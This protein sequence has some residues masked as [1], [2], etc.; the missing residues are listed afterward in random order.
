LT[1][2]IRSWRSSQIR[3]STSR[4]QLWQ[5]GDSQQPPEDS[6]DD[7]DTFKST[8]PP[9]SLSS[10]KSPANQLVNL[11]S[12]KEQ[13][14]SFV[15]QLSI[16]KSLQDSLQ[17]FGEKLKQ[18]QLVLLSFCAGAI[19]AMTAIFVPIYS[20]V[21]TLSQ[22]V[23]LFETILGDLETAYV[24]EVD[25]NKLFETGISAMLR[26]LDP[27]TEFEGAQE[28]ADMAESIDGKYA[29]VGLVISG[30]DAKTMERVKSSKIYL[31]KNGGKDVSM[32]KDKES[33]GS[34]TDGVV[35]E[36]TDEEDGDDADETT[37]RQLRHALARAQE[38]GIRV[39]SAFEGYAFDYGLRVGDKLVAID[40]KPVDSD[41]TVESVRN[42]LRG[43]PGT[44]VTIAFERD[45]IDG[46]QTVSMPRAVVRTR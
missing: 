17:V 15:D 26:S 8:D 39:E 33:S 38:R 31:E 10:S 41:A 37:K 5:L 27:Y 11:D 46:V 32:Q 34:A 12:I 13:Y 9:S 14:Q 3:K 45:G 4:E 40:D 42:M 30:T 23:T 7:K 24:D 43:Q 6:D 29:G 28:A 21:E 35:D 36:A 2:R 1:H 16:P 25:S 18:F 20:H 19:I 22:P 44:T